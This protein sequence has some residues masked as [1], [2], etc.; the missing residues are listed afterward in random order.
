MAINILKFNVTL[1]ASDLRRLQHPPK[2]CQ[3]LKVTHQHGKIEW[4]GH[5]CARH[6]GV[7]GSGDIA[8]YIFNLGSRGECSASCPFRFTMGKSAVD[9]H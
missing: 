6:K 4:Q 9:T 2:C 3:H 5:P 8:P 1:I 7:R